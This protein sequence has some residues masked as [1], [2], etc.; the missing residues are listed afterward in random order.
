MQLRSVV[1]GLVLAVARL[2]QPAQ[3]QEKELATYKQTTG[4]SG[5]IKSVG[6]DTMV[7]TMLKWYRRLRKRF[8]PN[9]TTR[10]RKT[11]DRRVPFRR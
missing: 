3:A 11:R 4:V 7:T 5:S 9:V 1:F 6:S 10:S 8:I 2:G